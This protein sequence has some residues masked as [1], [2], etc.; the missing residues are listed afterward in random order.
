RKVRGA[1]GGGEAIALLADRALDPRATAV[2]TASDEPPPIVPV[3][4]SS[5]IVE[6]GGY[7][8]EAESPGTSLLVLPVEY[9]H[10]LHADLTT[11]A[12]NPP[13][14]LRANLTMVAILFGG[15]VEGT[16][17]LSYG[18]LSSRCRIEDWRDANALR[19]GEAR[20]WPTMR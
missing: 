10:C 13:R 11:T 3:S 20:E 1:A 9:S 4:R 7:R 17:K 19:L 5:L 6:R 8:I 15:H 2:L 14:L 16:L 12:A 18:P